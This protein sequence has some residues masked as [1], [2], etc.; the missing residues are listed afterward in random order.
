[1]LIKVEEVKEMDRFKKYSEDDITRKLKKIEYAIRSYTHN[2][3]L[4]KTIRFYSKIEDNKILLDT[5]LIRAEDTILIRDFANYDIF[6]V[7]KIDNG[8]IEVGEDIYNSNESFIA[9]VVYPFDIIEGALDVLEWDLK[10]RN[11]VGI[12]QESIS[13]HSVTY[14]DNDSS[15]TVN[16]LSSCI[17]WFFNTIYKSEDLNMNNLIGGNTIIQLMKKVDNVLN[18][19]GEDSGTFEEYLSFEGFLDYVSGE[20]G[21][22][23]F[24]ALINESTHIFVSDYIEIKEEEEKLIAV[25]NNKTYEIK[26]ID[27]PMGLNEQLEIYLK[28]IGGQQYG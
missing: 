3:F 11:K 6:V 8:K 23:N 5:E 28:L 2:Q 15:N 24:N 21:S 4:S 10:M 25:I 14:F 19:I 16:R 9:K 7:K 18:D 27:N 17:I 1:M 13:R 12:K 26:Y 22:A 20:V